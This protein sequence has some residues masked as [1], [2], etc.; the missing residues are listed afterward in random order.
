MGHGVTPESLAVVSAW[1]AASLDGAVPA[2]A[3]GVA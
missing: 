2:G 3:E 1:L